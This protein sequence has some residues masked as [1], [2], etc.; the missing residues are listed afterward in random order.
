VVYTWAQQDRGT[1][2][3]IDGQVIGQLDVFTLTH[4]TWRDTNGNG[5]PDPGEIRASVDQFRVTC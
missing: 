5:Q 3:N 1:L 2:Y 4:I